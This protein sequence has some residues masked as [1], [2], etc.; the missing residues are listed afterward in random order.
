MDKTFDTFLPDDRGGDRT[1]K[2]V[3]MMDREAT[4]WGLARHRLEGSRLVRAVPRGARV[5]VRTRL[6]WGAIALALLTGAACTEPPPPP[7]P[8]APLTTK[9]ATTIGRVTILLHMLIAVE[10]VEVEPGVFTWLSNE[11][12]TSISVEVPFART[13]CT[14]TDIWSDEDVVWDWGAEEPLAEDGWW[15]LEIDPTVPFENQCMA[16][17]EVGESRNLLIWT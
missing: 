16:I 2:G 15:D 1:E 5:A 11:R 6:Q 4:A 13:S 7:R 3:S 14:V 9:P 12:W 8:V 10:Y 17:F